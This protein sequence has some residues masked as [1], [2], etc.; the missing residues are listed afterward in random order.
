[1]KI[2]ILQVSN[3]GPL[4]TQKAKNTENEYKKSN[5][6]ISVPQRS[7]AAYGDLEN[8]TLRIQKL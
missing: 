3:L 2:Q 1:M 5:R 6:K 7:A 8:I 4:H